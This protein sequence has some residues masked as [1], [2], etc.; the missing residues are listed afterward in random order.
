MDCP[1]TPAREERRVSKERLDLRD[2]QV[3]WA[4]RDPQVRLDQW[5]SVVTL[6]LQ[7][8]QVSRVCL[9]LLAKREPREIQVQPVLLERT[10]LKVCEVS[11]EREACPALLDLQV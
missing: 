2:L 6:D 1:D 8:H 4:L 7:D 3:F 11:P 10:D 9:E 5:E